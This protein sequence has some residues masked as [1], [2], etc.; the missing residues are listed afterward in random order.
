MVNLKKQFEEISDRQ[1]SIIILGLDPK[2]VNERKI[3]LELSRLKQGLVGVKP[4]LAFY[5][6]HDGRINLLKIS[7]NVGPNLIRLLDLKS[8]DG[9]AT[10][11]A[12]FKSYAKHYEHV[13]V[14]PAA[15]CTADTIYKANALG[16]TT[17]SMGAMSFPG[18]L[19]E[20][21]LGLPL[22]KQRVDIAIKHGTS[23]FVMGA[24]SFVP[25]ADIEN[26]MLKY[27]NLKND[28]PITIEDMSDGE[29][30]SALQGRNELFKY[31]LEKTEGTEILFLVPGFGRQGGKLENF[32]ASG[33]EL[34]RCL[35]NAGS[36]ILKSDDPQKALLEMSARFNTSRY[37]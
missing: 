18:V 37:L 5:Q 19:R 24:T 34:N 1:K 27:R 3:C 17:T 33:I 29:L 7:K 25:E 9:A 30:Y 23:A 21:D 14:A 4:N 26:T 31:I 10:N 28:M 22:F 35:I 6:T 2:T 8:P 36:D 16:L 15:G 12:A 20:I 13:T 11:N 32:L